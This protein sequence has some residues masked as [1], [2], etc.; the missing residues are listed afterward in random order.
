[1]VEGL[2]ISELTIDAVAA[3]EHTELARGEELYRGHSA[4]PKL[5]G[6][7]VILVDD[8]IATGSTMRAAI[9]A[10]RAQNP[11]RLVVAVPAA[12]PSSCEE[13]AREVDEMVALIMPE[14][15]YAVGQWYE[16]FSQTTDAEEGLSVQPFEQKQSNHGSS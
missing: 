9:Q 12:A 6:K 5:H 7:I 14:D 2:G 11:A 16:N 3:Q 8:G 10:I 1:V 4:S 15:F 13:L